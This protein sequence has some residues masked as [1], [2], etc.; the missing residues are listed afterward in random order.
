MKPHFGV[1]VD[2]VLAHHLPAMIEIV[3]ELTGMHVTPDQVTDYY[4]AG[5]VS[6]DQMEVVFERC[7]ERAMELPPMAD[8]HLVNELPGAVT[9]VTHRPAEVAENITKEWL[10]QHG[11]RYDGIVFTKGRKSET[12]RFDYFIDDAPLNALDLASAGATTYLMGWP[13][14]RDSHFGEHDHRVV[15]VAGWQDVR[16]HLE[17]IQAWPRQVG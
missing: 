2:G 8:Y 4:F 14:N 5:L 11:I 15:R 16:A 7:M 13:Y 17:S 1:D 10:Y 3:A 6:R 9:I 12:G